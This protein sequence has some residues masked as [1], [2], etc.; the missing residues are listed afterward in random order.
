MN[1]LITITLAIIITFTTVHTSSGKSQG[2]AIPNATKSAMPIARKQ[3][4]G[5]LYFYTA[6]AKTG[7]CFAV[8]NGKIAYMSIERADKLEA[9]KYS[10]SHIARRFVTK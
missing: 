2:E 7:F 3:K 1:N 8:K 4:V 10:Y 5:K 6:R 9:K